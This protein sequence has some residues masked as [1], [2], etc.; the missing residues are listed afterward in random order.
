MSNAL[1]VTALAW[2]VCW[3]P[4]PAYACRCAEKSAREHFAA[5]QHVFVARASAPE[6][7]GPSD[8]V[9]AKL[10]RHRRWA[11][12]RRRSRSYT[13]AVL[14]VLKGKPGL[15][16]AHGTRAVERCVRNFSKDEI[17]LVYVDAKNRIKL[18]DGN[19][20][21]STMLA[22]QLP[23]TL[24]LAGASARKLTPRDLVA[25]LSLGGVIDRAPD[26]SRAYKRVRFAA[27]WAGKVARF[28]AA[29][30]MLTASPK[31]RD[32]EVHRVLVHETR[33]KRG[34][35]LILV[36]ASTV[37][38][39]TLHRVLLL[40]RGARRGYV[41]LHRF[42]LHGCAQRLT[43]LEDGACTARDGSCVVT[44]TAHCQ[45]S[46]GCKNAGRCTARGGKCVLEGEADCRRSTPCVENGKCTAL[47]GRCVIGGPADCADAHDCK[48]R[49]RCTFDK[50]SAACVV[51]S[52]ADCRS[53]EACTNQGRC[54]RKSP[55]VCVK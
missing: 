54:K 50:K 28:Q 33:R 23:E 5:A 42:T 51:G 53:S 36:E 12:L 32:V 43:C 2:L 22:R 19:A 37:A 1:T 11:L 45:R 47:R 7:H 44:A 46:K 16:F 55:E 17:A 35:A 13:L 9:I 21:L 31:A 29:R 25:A 27:R 8:R 38:S 14:H 52:D 39:T 26:A 3:A 20:L 34:R 15:A 49:G 30:A 4:R 24:E 18:C 6:V 40:R 10:P 48:R 41:L